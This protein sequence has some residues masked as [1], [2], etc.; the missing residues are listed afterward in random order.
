[1]HLGAHSNAEIRESGFGIGKSK[2]ICSGL[3]EAGRRSLLRI[4]NPESLISGRFSRSGQ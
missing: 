2:A 3:T 4:P 1:M